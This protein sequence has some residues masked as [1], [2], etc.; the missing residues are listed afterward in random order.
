MLKNL[1][2]D[3][4]EISHIH[5]GTYGQPKNIM[6]LATANNV[7]PSPNTLYNIKEIH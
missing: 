4:L 7:T 5:K 2:E 6:P 1:R 3:V